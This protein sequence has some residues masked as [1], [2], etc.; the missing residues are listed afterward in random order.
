MLAI[1][2]SEEQD[3][4]LTKSFFNLITEELLKSKELWL[5]KRA[6]RCMGETISAELSGFDR[7]KR[8]FRKRLEALCT[9]QIDDDKKP[10]YKKLQI[11]AVEV[12]Q[13]IRVD[14]SPWLK[15]GDS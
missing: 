15:P 9:K 13:Q 6:L 10:A 4:E 14:N 5:R 12:L 3:I 1:I 2:G 8:K 7:L 11:Y